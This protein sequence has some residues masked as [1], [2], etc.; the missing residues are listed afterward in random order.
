MIT[1]QQRLQITLRQMTR[2]LCAF[3]DLRNTVLPV[4]PE[5][6]SVMAEGY[7]DQLAELRSEIEDCLSVSKSAG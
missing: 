1:D 5:L 7:V 6:F 4:N 3:E 2:I